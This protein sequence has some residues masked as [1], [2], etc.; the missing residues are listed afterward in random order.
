MAAVSTSL[1]RHTP[2]QRPRCREDPSGM[3][4]LA[5]AALSCKFLVRRT[6][7]P[8]AAQHATSTTQSP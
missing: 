7:S 6:I 8:I 3:P 2:H 5:A 1:G 4:H